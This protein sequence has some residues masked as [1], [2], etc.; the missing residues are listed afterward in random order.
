QKSKLLDEC[1]KL[2][3]KVVENLKTV[4]EE[5]Q[6]SANDYGPPKDRYDSFRMQLL[7]KKDMYNQLLEKALLELYALEKI[8]L[9]KEMTR[10]G[11]GSL[12]ITNEQKIFVSIGLGKVIIDNESFYAVSIMVPLSKALEGKQKGETVILNGKKIEIIE[13]L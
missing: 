3:N 11:F 12:V 4:I 8:D 7:R 2:Q 13:V 9:K 5:S 10:V 1:K 6:Q